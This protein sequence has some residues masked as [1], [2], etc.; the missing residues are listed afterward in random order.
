[1]RVGS[2]RTELPGE[3]LAEIG[4]AAM[5]IVEPI[6]PAVSGDAH[7]TNDVRRNLPA[8]IDMASGYRCAVLG[9][10]HFAKGTRCYVGGQ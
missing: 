4:G 8:L 10:S 6:V 7:R 3:R 2:I 5:L 9:I 1:M